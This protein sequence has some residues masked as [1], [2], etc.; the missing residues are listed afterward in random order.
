M[1][2]AE[3]LNGT[4]NNLA[5]LP[6]VTIQISLSINHTW[7]YSS[8]SSS[9]TLNAS[10]LSARLKPAPPALSDSFFPFPFV[11]FLFFAPL[12]S[13]TGGA[14]LTQREIASALS[15]LMGY[16]RPLSCAQRL[17]GVGCGDTGFPSASLG[18]DCCLFFSASS[19]SLFRRSRART[20]RWK[21]SSSTTGSVV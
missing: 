19:S 3:A 21:L 17:G 13:P 11:L 10:T 5:Y 6:V 2:Q 15:V 1:Y 12:L 18:G 20:A 7:H 8:M 14:S 16:S 9:C 4:K